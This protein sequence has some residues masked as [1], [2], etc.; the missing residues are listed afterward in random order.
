MPGNLPGDWCDQH[1]VASHRLTGTFRYGV[2]G[3]LNASGG[4]VLGNT[5]VGASI[6]KTS[7]TGTGVIKGDTLAS[8]A[9]DA[10]FSVA[11][12]IVTRVV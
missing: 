9:P 12:G 3:G 5:V 6:A 11:D 1:C 8:T 2:Q 4:Y 10:D 7:W